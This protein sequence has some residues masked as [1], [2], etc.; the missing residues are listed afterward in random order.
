LLAYAII[1]QKTALANKGN[2]LKRKSLY[3]FDGLRAHGLGKYI[4]KLTANSALLLTVIVA[5]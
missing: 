5:E 3:L 4:T 1:L 2:G